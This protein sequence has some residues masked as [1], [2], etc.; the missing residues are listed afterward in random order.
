M[1][2]HDPVAAG[3]AE[4]PRVV[5]AG[6]LGEARLDEHRHRLGPALE[7]EHVHVGHR[8]VRLD[9]VDR[10]REDRPLER[11]APDA[12]GLEEPQR[13]GGEADLAERPD[14]EGRG[15]RARGASTSA[16]HAGRERSI[17]P[18]RTPATP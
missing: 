10:L 8:P 4:G 12:A 11:Q 6:D 16:A 7:R 18:R 14:E 5:A 15:C 13:P 17:A 9:V 3:V 2:L 1:Q